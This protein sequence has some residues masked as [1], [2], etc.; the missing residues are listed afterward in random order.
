MDTSHTEISLR[1][2]SFNLHG[3]SNSLPY[4]QE[5]CIDNDIIFVQEHWLMKSDLAKFDD[6]SSD[7]RFYG[8]SAMDSKCEQ[9]LLRGRP[10]GGV[11]V[12]YRKNLN[13]KVTL[14]GCMPD[15]RAVAIVADCG[16]LKLLCFGLYLPCE[17]HSQAYLSTLSNIFGF[18]ESTKE[19][20]SGCK[21]I[22]LGDFNFV[23]NNYSRGFRE[24]SSVVVCDDLDVC[25]M[26]VFHIFMS[27]W[28]TN[29]LLIMF[30]YLQCC[31][32]ASLNTKF[33]MTPST[34]QITSLC[35]LLLW[36][37]VM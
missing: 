3:L 20:N 37:N 4:L 19:S 5:L 11:G 10:F 25:M 28:A 13:I 18:I 32:P 27:R 2:C 31:D 17:D 12:L 23:C 36:F 33:V 14:S 21:C 15:G 34:C 6:I 1:V 35:N 24:F 22:V 29:H 8:A 7:F 26:L 16:T 9:G 30:S